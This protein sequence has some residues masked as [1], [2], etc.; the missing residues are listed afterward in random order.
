[1]PVKQVIV[2]RRDLKM[3]RGK[4]CAQSA[5]SS[6]IWLSRRVIDGRKFALIWVSIFFM[7]M[8]AVGLLFM[9]E[10]VNKPSLLVAYIFS[11][12]FLCDCIL[13]KFSKDELEWLTGS[14]TKITLQ[15]NSE[16]DLL[17]VYSNALAAG[18]TT[19]LVRDIGK[20]EFGGVPT[21]TAIAIGPNKNEDIDV[22]TKDLELY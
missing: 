16:V 19:H 15:V 11:L 9:V 21:I 18:F 10:K 20:T 2:I 6:M 5:H 8:L 14:F 7:L 17:A 4:E 13:P 3:R 22:V 1:M 12:V